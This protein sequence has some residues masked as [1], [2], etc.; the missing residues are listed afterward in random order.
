MAQTESAER[1]ADVRFP[2]PLVWLAALVVGLVI[3]RFVR[4]APF[5]IARAAG[6]I[7]GA[8]L[9]AIGAAL[10]VS[11]RL[12]FKRTGQS[13]RPWDPTPSLIFEG[14][15]RFTRNPM[16]V[17]LTLFQIGLGLM[18]NSIWASALAVL[19]LATV[20]FIAVLPEERYLSRKF[21][22]SYRDYLGRVRRYL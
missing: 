15:Y 4:A 7:I 17:G 12:H 14:P 1:G 21:G 16:Y 9:M 2:P 8:I 10:A 22:D 13:V 19:A 5:P 3:D 11:A 18:L 20:H 6:L